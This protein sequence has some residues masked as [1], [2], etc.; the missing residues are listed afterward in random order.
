MGST[1]EY[2]D[3]NIYDLQK[4][5]TWAMEFVTRAQETYESRIFDDQRPR[6]AIEGAIDFSNSGKRTN[7]LR[8]LALDA[9][10]ASIET[11]DIV[12]SYAAK[13]SSLIAAVAFTHPYRDIRQAEHLLGPIVYCALAEEIMLGN[14]GI[15]DKIVERAI[16]TVSKEIALLLIQYPKHERMN[17]RIEKLYYKLEN[18]IRSKF[19][20]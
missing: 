1:K 14:E 18:G 16:V 3:I 8:K 9:Y 2:F 4:T 15:G 13:A 11:K 7:V 6:K 10:R 20:Y 19:G 17:T 5:V 12:A